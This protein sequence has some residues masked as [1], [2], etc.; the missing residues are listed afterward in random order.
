M[1]SKRKRTI[2]ILVAAVIAALLAALIVI[3][4]SRSGDNGNDN[5]SEPPDYNLLDDTNNENN[6]QNDIHQDYE[7]DSN[8]DYNDTFP[9]GNPNP[10]PAEAAFTHPPAADFNGIR[11]DPTTG[12]LIPTA[13]NRVATFENPNPGNAPPLTPTRFI[14]VGLGGSDTNPGTYDQPFATLRRAVEVVQPGQAIRLLPG[15]YATVSGVGSTSHD[16]VR[17]TAEAPIWI[18][19]VPG[20]ERPVIRRITINQAQYV[21][22]HD[23][24]VSGH[25]EL[26]HGIHFTDGG[27]IASPGE[28]PAAHHIVFRN[29]LVHDIRIGHFKFA[30]MYNVWMFDVELADNS[31]NVQDGFTRGHGVINSVGCHNFV[32]AYNYFHNLAGNAIKFKGGSSEVDIFGNLFV[33]AGFHNVQMGQFT[34]QFLFRP[35]LQS[36]P[37]STCVEAHNIRTYSNIMIGA[38]AGFVFQGG[39]HNYA[40]N[41]TI[42]MPFRWIYRVLGVD[43][44]E[45]LYNYGFAR[46]GTIANNLFVFDHFPGGPGNYLINVG[47]GTYPDTFTFTNNLF[48]NLDDPGQLPAGLDSFNHTNT[49]GNDPLLINYTNI[50]YANEARPQVD[51]PLPQ[52]DCWVERAR[53]VATIQ[54]SDLRLSADSPAIGAG[55][56]AFGFVTYDFFGRPFGSTPSIGAAEFTVEFTR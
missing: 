27:V 16:L 41:N 49:I 17:G 44:R 25:N 22:F 36:P 32:V 18:G 38:G 56:D 11:L 29:L 33:N 55:S 28:E 9:Y 30:G 50:L 45:Y 34:G 6:E 47:G 3:L 13:F 48:F 51:W 53:R 15:N 39:M 14:Y 1:K 40:V 54:V 37:T 31:P 24:E 5:D 4:I 12:R 23:I 46:Y 35:P 10:S 26:Y 43:A 2:I 19:G 7:P 52:D 8:N 20:M 21:I 42:I